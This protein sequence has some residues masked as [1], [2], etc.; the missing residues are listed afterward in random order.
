MQ[1]TTL[2][3]EGVEEGTLFGEYQQARV[4]R[5]MRSHEIINDVDGE[6]TVVVR[7]VGDPLE[8]SVYFNKENADLVK[9]SSRI[10]TEGVL[11]ELAFSP[12]VDK[13]VVRKDLRAGAVKDVAARLGESI[14]GQK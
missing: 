5:F 6:E 2:G 7:E 8:E 13:L 10:A 4:E 1:T 14:Q 12:T 9:K 11:G 3:F